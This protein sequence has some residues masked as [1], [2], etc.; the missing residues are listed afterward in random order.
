MAC[1]REA[2]GGTDG[3]TSRHLR[4]RNPLDASRWPAVDELSFEV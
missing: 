4:D 1:D 3:E 2:G